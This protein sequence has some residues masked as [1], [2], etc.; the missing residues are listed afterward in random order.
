L[1]KG[2][3]NRLFER[4]RIFI[5]YLKNDS[6]TAAGKLKKLNQ[7]AHSKNSG[8]LLDIDKKTP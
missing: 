8:V 5:V 2:I 7:H 3:S 4:F 1:K 6:T